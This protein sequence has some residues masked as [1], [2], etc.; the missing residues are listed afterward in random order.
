MKG[1]TK[2]LQRRGK[3]LG[4]CCD[5]QM[6][7]DVAEILSP[8]ISAPGGPRIAVLAPLNLPDMTKTVEDLLRSFA[9]TAVQT[10]VDLGADPVVVDVSSGEIPAG[11]D[12]RECDAVLLLGGGDIDA[13]LYGGADPVPNEY[14]VDRAVDEVSIRAVRDALSAEVP[15][16]G[17]CRGSQVLNVAL[18]GT[19]IPD[20]EDFT[21]HRGQGADP[22]MIDERVQLLSPSRLRD[23][24]EADQV[25][26]RSGHHQAIAQVATDLQATAWALDGIVEA[27]EHR[28]TWAIGVQWHPEDP[29][30]S[31]EDRRRLFG[32]F[33]D[34]ARRRRDTHRSTD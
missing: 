7:I 9:R 23:I 8:D 33:V 10:L 26:G 27:V 5:P 20:I 29:Y 22:V 21:L 18:G 13:S 15:V 24:F 25:V 16:L 1:S 12:L 2:G 19:L 28:E 11:L 30:G 3:E 32:A 6:S 17:I 4:Q 14:G 31:V 34:A